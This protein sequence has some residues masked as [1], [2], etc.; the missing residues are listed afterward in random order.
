MIL[1]QL[2]HLSIWQLSEFNI[3]LH[4]V[5]SQF[6]SSALIIIFALNSPQST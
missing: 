6:I 2:F 3:E 5:C 4:V 1:H